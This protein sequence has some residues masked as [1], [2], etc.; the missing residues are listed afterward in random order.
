MSVPWSSPRSMRWGRISCWWKDFGNYASGSASIGARLAVLQQRR[1]ADEDNWQDPRH[2][3]DLLEAFVR[4]IGA[5]RPCDR[6]E[7]PFFGQ[8][9]VSNAQLPVMPTIHSC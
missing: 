7:G 3:A 9:S 2:I 6:T 4:W 5:C 8:N 1:P